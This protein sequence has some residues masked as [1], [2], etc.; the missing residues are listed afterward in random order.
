MIINWVIS[1][2]R[3]SPK[4]SIK[5]VIISSTFLT[6]SLTVFVDSC[7]KWILTLK[8]HIGHY[9]HSN[10]QLEFVRHQ[11]QLNGQVLLPK[12]IVGELGA[13]HSRDYVEAPHSE[14]NGR[15]EDGQEVQE[16][17]VVQILSIEG[18]HRYDFNFR[19]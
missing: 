12:L 7:G 4:I 2:K 5:V 17:L 3:V 14:Q 13:Q 15:E 1:A 16:Q 6:Q 9:D 18:D 8:V 10:Q 19:T 11:H